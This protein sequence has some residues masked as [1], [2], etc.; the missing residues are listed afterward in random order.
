MRSGYCQCSLGSSSGPCPH[1]NAVQKHY[2][3]AE[4][5]VIPTLDHKIRRIYHFIALGRHLDD[6]HYRSFK[7]RGADENLGNYVAE[8]TEPHQSS[9]STSGTSH[10]DVPQEDMDD[11]NEVNDE[12]QRDAANDEEE[13]DAVTNEEEDDGDDDEHDITNDDEDHAASDDD[14]QSED[15]EKDK[16]WEMHMENVQ[17]TKEMVDNNWRDENFKKAF[18]S[19]VK[20]Y[21]TAVTSNPNTF[22]RQLYTFGNN[23]NM[24]NSRT[25]PLQSTAVARRASQYKAK[26]Q[27]RTATIQGRRPKE[28]PQQSVPDPEN[29]GLVYHTYPTSQSK[30]RKVVHS[31]GKSIEDNRQNAR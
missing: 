29:D 24:K 23:K 2:N 16:F 18:I 22:V 19:H 17:L 6:N 26:G 20:K 25:I 8:H 10:H 4:F 5:S 1:K 9:S 31:L 11:D 14:E 3:V 21:R 15:N 30:K 7:K 13:Y 27:G 28:V 12:E